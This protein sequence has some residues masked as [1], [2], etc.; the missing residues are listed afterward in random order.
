MVQNILYVTYVQNYN[1]G[2]EGYPKR[3]QY[4]PKCDYCSQMIYWIMTNEGNKPFNDPQGS[5]RHTCDEFKKYRESLQKQ[6]SDLKDTV[7]GLKN[8]IP[9]I[10]S[11]IDK[12]EKRGV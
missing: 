7:E 2:T 12:L 10:L 9:K 8:V 11:K 4:M 5:S 1:I 3:R 6:I